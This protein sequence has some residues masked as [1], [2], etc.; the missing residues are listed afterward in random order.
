[1]ERQET[2]AQDGCLQ[3]S[4]RRS[5]PLEELTDLAIEI[6]KIM[7]DLPPNL[8]ELFERLKNETVTEV[9]QDTGIP[10][11]SIYDSIKKF[12]LMLENAGLENYF[13]SNNLRNSSLVSPACS[14]IYFTR[15]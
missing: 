5:R 12:R 11:G 2:I 10:R 6:K 8:R 15:S 3:R 13:P 14:N 7:A 9:S 4:G 1:M